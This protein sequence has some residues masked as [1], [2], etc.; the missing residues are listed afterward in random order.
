MEEITYFPLPQLVVFYSTYYARFECVMSFT[1]WLCSL[2]PSKQLVFR[3]C[4][5]G[6]VNQQSFLS[7]QAQNYLNKDPKWNLYPSG[8]TET[9]KG[10]QPSRSGSKCLWSK[11]T[12]L[13]RTVCV[14][15]IWPCI[16]CMNQQVQT[17]IKR[18]N[19]KKNVDGPQCD[20][21]RSRL[22]SYFR[23]SFDCNTAMTVLQSP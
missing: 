22:S 3:H 19:P 10:F 23:E 7:Y 21:I 6:A 11:H 16:T 14:C 8:R 5:G 20:C 4:P 9:P 13:L 17:L 2:K 18:H 15:V 1:W 12:I